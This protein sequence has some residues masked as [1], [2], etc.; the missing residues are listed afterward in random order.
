MTLLTIGKLAQAVGVNVETIR[1]YQRR[2][3][4]D[5][6]AKPPG[7]HRSYTSEHIKRVR[8]I[9]RAQALGFTLVE[10]ETLLAIDG[11]DLCR[12]TRKM[13]LHKTALIDR[14]I[15]ELTML[16]GVLDSLIQKCEP[17]RS[18]SVCPIIDVLSD[19]IP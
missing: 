10:I 18:K 4:L 1:F 19:D 13:V 6:P 14:K 3:L 2:G 9:R 15:S 7:G 5:Q 12:D 8:F 17:G 16:R 11:T